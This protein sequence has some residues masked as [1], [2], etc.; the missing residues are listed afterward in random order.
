[1][2]ETVLPTKI[3]P[4]VLLDRIHTENVCMKEDDG[5]I[6]LVPVQEKKSWR[7][8]FGIL[9]DCPEITV[10]RASC[11][12]ERFCFCMVHEFF[13]RAFIRVIRG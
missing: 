5:V 3:L 2:T 4:E 9:A 6:Q 13:I 12:A 10:D 7:G 8:V 1:M 11:V